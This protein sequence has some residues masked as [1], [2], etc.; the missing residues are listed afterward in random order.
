M[1]D[2][3]QLMD[4]LARIMAGGAGGGLSPSAL[5]GTGARMK[6]LA[7]TVTPALLSVAEILDQFG[8][9]NRTLIPSIVKFYE[10]LTGKT[11]DVSRMARENLV[12][13]LTREIDRVTMPAIKKLLPEN[14]RDGRRTLIRSPSPGG[15]VLAPGDGIS[16]SRWRCSSITPWPST[17]SMR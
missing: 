1:A 16:W 14:N 17:F 15:T 13:V 4:D 2:T 7:M 6:S 8:Y 11:I 12:S 9:V 5:A 10:D 3:L